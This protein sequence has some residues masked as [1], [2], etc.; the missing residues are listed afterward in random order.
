MQAG[1]RAMDV[2]PGRRTAPGE[3]LRLAASQ[4]LGFRG[5][6][7]HPRG[8]LPRAARFAL[9][10]AGAAAGRDSIDPASSGCAP[11]RHLDRHH[12]SR[13]KATA[14]SEPEYLDHDG[15]SPC[16][17]GPS[18]ATTC[19]PPNSESLSRQTGRRVQCAG[20]RAAPYDT[21]FQKPLPIAICVPSVQTQMRRCRDLARRGVRSK[22][23]RP[24]GIRRRAAC[25]LSRRTDR[26]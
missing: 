4:G 20:R 23:S 14:D 10:G 1:S 7:W 9:L 25:R 26:K 8:G 18:I 2:L 19:M 5:A 22:V 15:R 12:Q 13:R 24:P 17:D 21:S 3:S 16:R 11:G 6:A